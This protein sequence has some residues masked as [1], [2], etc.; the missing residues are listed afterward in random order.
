MQAVFLHQLQ[1]C[2]QP[3]C[4]LS[5]CGLGYLKSNSLYIT[6]WFLNGRLLAFPL[7]PGLSF[8]LWYLA[9]QELCAV[10]LTADAANSHPQQQ[11]NLTLVRPQGTC[12]NPHVKL[13][14]AHIPLSFSKIQ[15]FHSGHS[16]YQYT[17]LWG[18]P[19][20]IWSLQPLVI[21]LALCLM[22]PVATHDQL[23]TGNWISMLT[24]L[25]L[26]QMSTP[27]N[28]RSSARKDLMFHC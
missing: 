14:V 25:L 23:H 20:F 15:M 8:L 4:W 12:I 18:G 19:L 9:W 21:S 7:W 24:P 22:I 11:I 26:M 16:F 2:V 1:E 28:L 17:P 5:F 10:Y 6:N 3:L 27:A 13:L